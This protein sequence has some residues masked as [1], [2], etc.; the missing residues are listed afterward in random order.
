M[1][2]IANVE[3]VDFLHQLKIGAAMTKR[4]QPKSNKSESRKSGASYLSEDND[5]LVAELEGFGFEEVEEEVDDD[6]SADEESLLEE[7]DEDASYEVV[8]VSTELPHRF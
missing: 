3:S 5:V 2:R 4:F 7:E 1:L 8:V 6:H